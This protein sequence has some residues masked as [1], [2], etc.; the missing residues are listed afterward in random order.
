MNKRRQQ[1]I[2]TGMPFMAN[3]APR[4]FIDDMG[5]KLFLAKHPKRIISLAPSITE[6]LYAIGSGGEIVGVTEFCNFPEEVKTKPKVGYAQPN[7]ESIVSLQPDLILAPKSFVRVDL[8][9]KL[10]QLKIP[11]FILEAHTVEEIMAHIKLLGRMVGRSDAANEQTTALRK[12]ISELSDR[13]KG[14]TRPRILYVLNSD[15]LITVGPGSFIHHLIEL[16][17]GQNVAERTA[18]PYPRLAMEEVLRQNPEVLLFPVGRF[19]GIPPAEQDQWKRWTTLT[20][21][22]EGKLFQVESDLLNRPG[23][24]I[25]QALRQLVSLLHPDVLQDDRVAVER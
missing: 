14:R 22:K 21:V 3:V 5:R 19:E 1:G 12:Q 9:K 23:P 24:R 8:L 13:L 18:T 20:A 2:L 10:E 6:M 7:I 25:I 11:T 16:A 4:T 17:G 15:P